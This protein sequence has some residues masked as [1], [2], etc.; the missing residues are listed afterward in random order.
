MLTGLITLLAVVLA[1]FTGIVAPAETTAQSDTAVTPG[2]SADEI[3]GL[4]YMVEEEKLAHDVYTA[5]GA[6]WG[7]PVF[8]MIARSEAAHQQAVRQVLNQFA[9]ADPSAAN[10]PG[11]FT[12]ATLQA[13]YD[14]MVAEG[15]VSLEA[16]LRVGALIEEVDI[17]DLQASL[18]TSRHEEISN[19][20]QR[21]LSG[22]GN[23]LR[24]YAKQIERVTGEP[25]T[26]RY[27]D[28]AEY[29]AILGGTNG[30]GRGGQGWGSGGQGGNQ[31]GRGG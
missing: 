21:L 5:L 24:A 6:Q 20:Y 13:L 1:T 19:L 22:S 11:L 25:Y 29:A 10:P 23:H 27:L 12:D 15:S 7:T 30:H 8:T 31:F 14:E 17:L 26:P 2:L 9:I 3:A 18:A 16:A 4:Q 28:P